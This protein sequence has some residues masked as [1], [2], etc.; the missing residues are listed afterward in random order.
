MHVKARPTTR[1]ALQGPREHAVD[2]ARRRLG[3]TADRGVIGQEG[4]V[5][6]VGLGPDLAG[7]KAIGPAQQMQVVVVEHMRFALKVEFGQ[8]E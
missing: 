8:G 7:H 1:S 2:L 4:I 3:H 5:E 6:A